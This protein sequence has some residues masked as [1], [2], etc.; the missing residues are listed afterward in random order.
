MTGEI[1]V[2]ADHRAATLAGAILN[3]LRVPLLVLNGDLRVIAAS[4][5]F[6]K[7]FQV[8]PEETTGRLL[9]DLGNGQWDIP[10]LRH[11]LEDV[12]PRHTTMEAFEVEHEFPQLG[13]RVMSLDAREIRHPEADSPG[14]RQGSRTFFIKAS[15][16]IRKG[17]WDD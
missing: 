16:L 13:H 8:L 9:F 7:T 1:I 10:A 12:I 2:N 4:P 14:F 11:L 5:S 6:S 17:F 15:Y 3:T